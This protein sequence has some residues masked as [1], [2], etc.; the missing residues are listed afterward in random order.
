MHELSCVEHKGKKNATL[1]KFIIYE[2]LCVHL[3]ASEFYKAALSYRA[4]SMTK[5]KRTQIK[6]SNMQFLL[7]LFCMHFLC[8]CFL[9]DVIQQDIVLSDTK[10]TVWMT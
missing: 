7:R 6:Q 1:E 8:A 2:F 9:L 10:E 4:F 3:S 5:E